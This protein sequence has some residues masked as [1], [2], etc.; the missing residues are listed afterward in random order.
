MEAFCVGL[1]LV[2]YERPHGDEAN[3]LDTE[4]LNVY[5]TNSRVFQPAARSF[6]S[7]EQQQR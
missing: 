6:Q 2:F 3:V 4:A 5:L 1:A 7:I